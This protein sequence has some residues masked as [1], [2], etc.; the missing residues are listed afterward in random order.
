MLSLQLRVPAS[1]PSLYGEYALLL[2]ER[3]PAVNASLHA[4]LTA[5]TSGAWGGP[6]VAVSLSV[7]SNTA[8]LRCWRLLNELLIPTGAVLHPH[9]G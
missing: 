1:P 9:S 7:R 6:P 3:L 4:A 5:V 8:C 2:G